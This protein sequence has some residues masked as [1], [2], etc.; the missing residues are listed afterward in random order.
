MAVYIAQY[1]RHFQSYPDLTCSTC[2]AA[3]EEMAIRLNHVNTRSQPQALLTLACK[4]VETQPSLHVQLVS[5]VR[6]SCMLQPTLKMVLALILLQM[7][8]GVAHSKEP[9]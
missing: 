5:A 7:D 4:C 2:T 3:D 9:F 6:G 8:F 1:L